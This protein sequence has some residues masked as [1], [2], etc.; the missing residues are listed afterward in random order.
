MGLRKLTTEQ[1]TS[2]LPVGMEAAW[3]C[4]DAEDREAAGEG[5]AVLGGGHLSGCVEVGADGCLVK[6]PFWRD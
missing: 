3:L 4:V 6:A 5:S 2:A 1:P